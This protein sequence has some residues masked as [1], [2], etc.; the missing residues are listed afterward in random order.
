MVCFK[1]ELVVQQSRELR[2]LRSTVTSPRE[3][4]DEALHSHTQR[5]TQAIENALALG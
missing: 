3:L 5:T 4:I 2:S 1:T